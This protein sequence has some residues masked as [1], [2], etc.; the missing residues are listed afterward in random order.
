MVKRYGYL[1]KRVI[2][3]SNLELAFDNACDGHRYKRQ[4]LEACAR[5]KDFLDH[6]EMLLR[7]KTYKS[8]EYRAQTIHERGKTRIVY[9]TDF[10]HR[11]IHHALMNILKPILMESIGHHSFA[12]MQGRG[13]HQALELTKKDLQED[14]EGTRYCFQF[15]IRQFFPTIPKKG[16]VEALNRKI[17]DPDVQWLYKEI[18]FGFPYDGLPIGNYTSQYFANYYL[19]RLDH[20]LKAEF[21]AKHARHYMD[22]YII[23]GKTTAWL[24]RVKKRVVQLLEEMGL[25]LKKDWQIYKVGD[26]RPVDFVG[27]RMYRDSKGQVY[28]LLRKR[29]VKALKHVCKEAERFIFEHGLPDKHIMGSLHSYQG[30]LGWGNCYNLGRKTVYKILDY[31]GGKEYGNL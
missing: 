20:F 7:T 22:N 2:E 5:R 15:D 13:S 4:V 27:Y 24:R 6:V 29:T 14:P 28:T 26:R 11:V 9:D 25:E 31:T 17:K 12:A 8:G 18:I 3:R 19:S 1:W 30:V 23:F 21:H 10:I 16:M